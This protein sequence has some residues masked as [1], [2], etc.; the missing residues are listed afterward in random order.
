MLDPIDKGELSVHVDT[1]T[2]EEAMTFLVPVAR[3][4]GWR[5]SHINRPA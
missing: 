3:V 2:T 1:L 5:D 4:V